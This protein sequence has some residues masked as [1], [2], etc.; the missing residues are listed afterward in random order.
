MKVNLFHFRR[1]E[2]AVQEID[3]SIQIYESLDPS[4]KCP[5]R[6]VSFIQTFSRIC[7][8]K[9]A[10][11]FEQQQR[12]QVYPSHVFRYLKGKSW[13]ETLLFAIQTGVS[14]LSDARELVAQLQ[15]EAGQQERLL[16]QKQME[17]KAALQKIT[18]TIQNAG[19]KR[20][21]MQDLRSTIANENVALTH[22]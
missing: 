11:I 4:L 6:Y 16:A 2:R 10:G 3:K 17:A 19:V 21:E 22:R 8:K 7:G 1:D 15:A 12:I 5:R 20:D 9:T 18:D 13:F 14:K